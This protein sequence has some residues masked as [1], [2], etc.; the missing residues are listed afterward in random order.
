MR[1]GGLATV[2]MARS[3]PTLSRDVTRKGDRLQML[4]EPLAG[5]AFA[6]A[7]AAPFTRNA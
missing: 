6:G 2:R 7:G 5:V 1:G 4:V 3:G